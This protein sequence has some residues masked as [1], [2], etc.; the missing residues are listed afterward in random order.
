MVFTR[1]SFSGR[2]VTLSPIDIEN[3]ADL[4]VASDKGD[5][6]IWKYLAEPLPEHALDWHHF[7]T[8]RAKDVNSPTTKRITFA[9]TNTIGEEMAIGTTS[10]YNINAKHKTADIGYT[11]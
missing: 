4:W 11:W 1:T 3:A 10:V 6:E 5:K 2:T 8:A 7:V 9:I